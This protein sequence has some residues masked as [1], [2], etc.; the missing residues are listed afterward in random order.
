MTRQHEFNSKHRHKTQQH[1]AEDTHTHTPVALWLTHDSILAV[2]TF[3]LYY[4]EL[5]LLNFK[6]IKTL[7][8]VFTLRNHVITLLKLHKI[9]PE[10]ELLALYSPP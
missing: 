5:L 4:T 9:K 7:Q 3:Y 6:K 1:L 8:H 10:A 2:T